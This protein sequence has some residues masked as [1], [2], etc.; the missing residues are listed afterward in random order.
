MPESLGL[1]P[2]TYPQAVWGVYVELGNADGRE[3]LLVLGDGSV[4]IQR[5]RGEAVI[6]TGEDANVRAAATRLLAVANNALGASSPAG[7]DPP[8][9][10][11]ETRFQL[12]TYRGT[13]VAATQP[14]LLRA[15]Q[16][17]LAAA[18][19]IPR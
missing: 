2:M 4:R 7:V 19:L 13:R 8:V 10:A 12:L 17:V 11:G 18:D 9:T 14:E 16:A 5:R 1:S 6:E 3:T 15:A